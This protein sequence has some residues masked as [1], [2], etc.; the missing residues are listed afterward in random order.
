[1]TTNISATMIFN[2][3]LGLM[4]PVIDNW[5]HLGGAVGGAAMA[6]YFG[7]RLY[8][9]ELPNGGRVIVDR[10]LFRMPRNLEMIP[11]NFG[12][13]LHRISHRM[14]VEGVKSEMPQRP[15]QRRRREQRMRQN[16][17]TR[18]VKPGKVD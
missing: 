16:A 5:A 10:P 2:V 12:K 6:Y 11:E 18:S 13:Q 7:P 8:L 15:W 14:R 17:P 1:M 3:F 4:N 9:S